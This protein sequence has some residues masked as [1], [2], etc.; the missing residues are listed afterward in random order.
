MTH[1]TTWTGP[2]IDGLTLNYDGTTRKVDR[3]VPFAEAY[4]YG[5]PW[6]LNKHGWIRACDDRM[7]DR[8]SNARI[9]ACVNACRGVPTPVLE[10]GKVSITWKERR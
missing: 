7:I 4:D 3:S 6:V 2:G 1:R 8:E 5:E 10:S 9:V